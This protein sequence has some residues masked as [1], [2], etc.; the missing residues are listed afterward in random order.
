MI[1]NEM[2]HSLFH[3]LRNFLVD[4]VAKMLYRALSA[5]QNDR[6]RVVWCLSS[7]LG[8]DSDEVECFPHPLNELVDVEPLLGRDGNGHGDLVEKVEFFY[9]NCVDLVEDVERWDVYTAVV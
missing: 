8:I 9:R 3:L 7:R 6:L 5:T 4:A 2:K 1:Y